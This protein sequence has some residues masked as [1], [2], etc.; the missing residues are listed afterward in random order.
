MSPI[1][2]VPVRFSALRLRSCGDWDEGQSVTCALPTVET[3]DDDEDALPVPVPVGIITVLNRN[4]T[5]ETKK[6]KKTV[7]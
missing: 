6:E 7:V 2:A 4:K 1:L 3:R 5:T